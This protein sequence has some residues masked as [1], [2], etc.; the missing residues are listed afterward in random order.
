MKRMKKWIAML[1]AGGM[2]LGTVGCAVAPP[3]VDNPHS[4]DSE[5]KIANADDSIE[6][7]QALITSNQQGRTI[8]LLSGDIYNFAD[9]YTK[10]C[11]KD[12]AIGDFKVDR[13]APKPLKLTWQNQ[14]E[15]AL[16]Y[17]VKIGTDKSLSDAD[18]YLVTENFVE[19]EYLY[20]A[21][22]YYYQIYAHYEND[23]VLKS[24][25][26][27][28]RTADLPRTVHIEG[29]S[30]TRDL[31]GR[32]TVDGTHRVKQGMIYRGG[33]VDKSWGAI[34]E[35]GKR[36]MV[37]ELGIKTDLDLRDHITLTQS[38]IDAS[39]NYVN[40]SAP[41]YIGGDGINSA[42]YKDALIT[43]VR[44]FANPD[45]YPVYLHCSLGR[46]RAGTLAF[47][48]SALLGV[49]ELDLYRDYEMSFFSV[50]GWADASQGA[51]KF[52]E[53]VPQAFTNLYNYIKNYGNGTLAENT[54]AFMKNYLG[55]TQAEIDT[56]R[57]VMLEEVS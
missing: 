18:S 35:E 57:N 29:V 51:G 8:A 4:S 26:F 10:F 1:L 19:I 15:G 3:Q 5:E 30:N 33:E 40:V 31:G 37:H 6:E 50:N 56:I 17:T 42:D 43:E 25:V 45:N 7:Y 47:L 52:D 54:E 32:L 22:Q 44:T 21:K 11:G 53:L 49:G 23:E 27:D 55:I 28:F 41:Y 13:Y 16:Y 38:P 48:I 46:D 36:V 39:L 9:N 20:A 12:Y 34:T 2:T 14:R 24:R